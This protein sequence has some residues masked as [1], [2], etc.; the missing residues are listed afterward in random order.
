MYEIFKSAERLG[1][2][3]SRIQEKTKN[4]INVFLKLREYYGV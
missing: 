1:I 4:R 3:I 2:K